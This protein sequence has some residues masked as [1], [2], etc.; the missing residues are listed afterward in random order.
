MIEAL[1]ELPRA[2]WSFGGVS[3]A[4]CLI[5]EVAYSGF[6]KVGEKIT[7]EVEPM[8]KTADLRVAAFDLVP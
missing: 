4:L 2:L 3:S 7:G 5:E 8:I 6:S 1:A